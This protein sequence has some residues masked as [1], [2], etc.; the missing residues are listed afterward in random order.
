MDGA[1]S[2]QG[3]CFKKNSIVQIFLEANNGAK[4]SVHRQLRLRGVITTLIK[5][6]TIKI[7]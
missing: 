3:T 4:M 1:G 7:Y 5:L 6:W 2:N